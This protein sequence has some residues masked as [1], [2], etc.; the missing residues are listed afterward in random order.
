MEKSGSII[1]TPDQRLRVFISSTLKELADERNSV[2][3]SVESLRLI[4]VMFELGARPHPPKDLYQAYLFQS[5]IFIGIYWQSY[6]WIA[7]HET[8]SGIEDE[9][10]LSGKLPRLIY[11]K[12]PASEREIKLDGLLDSVRSAGDVSYKSFSNSEELY[13]LVTDDLAI[14]ISERFYSA[15]NQNPVVSDTP[16]I[17]TFQTNLPSRLPE[18]IGRGRELEDLRDLIIEEKRNLISITG[19]G[20]IGKTLLSKALAGTLRDHFED[21][22]YFIDLSDI[23][24]ENSVFVEIASV[25]GV[26]ISEPENITKQISDFISTQKILLILDNFEHL[27]S[28]SSEISKLSLI[29]PELTIIITSRDSLKISFEI[30]YR[31][32]AL[33]VPSVSDEFKEIA[34]SPS[35]KL[36][37]TKARSADNNFNLN[38]DNI[39]DVAEIC[40]ILEGI[41]LA[42][43]L[44]AA[45]VRIFSPA[46]ILSRLSKK[47]LILSGGS[48]DAP[49]RHKTMRA[50][51][52]WSIELLNKDE[53]I[54]FRRLAVF[55]DGFDYEALESIC[56][57]CSEG[58]DELS[59]SLILKNIIKKDSEIN[60]IA[61]Y[62]MPGMI[63]EYAKEL[64]ENS[65]EKDDI[66]MKHAYY[67]LNSAKK[68][69]KDFTG[70]NISAAS[71]KWG[72]D[73]ENVIEAAYTFLQ[74]EK[75]SELVNL[76]NSLWQLFWIFDYEAELEKKINL[77]DLVNFQDK[78]TGDD[79]GKLIWLAGVTALGKGDH[80]NAEKYLKQAKDLFEISGNKNGYA[81]AYH[82][83]ASI[84][85]ANMRENSNK[86]IL[87]S[88]EKSAKLFRE[89]GDFWGECSVLQNTAALETLMKHY[90]KA[91]K[92]YDDYEILAKRTK[93]IA[94]QGYINT[95][96]GWIFTNS[97]KYDQALI[98]L[99]NGM[100]FFKDGTTPE[101]LCYTLIIISFYY[102]KIKNESSA[103][104]IAGAQENIRSKYS[105]THWQMLNSVTEFLNT[106]INNNNDLSLREAYHEGM[107]M[108][109][110]KTACTAY[111]ML[112]K[113]K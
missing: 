96:R 43:N 91:L 31:V 21:G 45:K 50:A 51:I 28:S 89:I 36:F 112:Q 18:L 27:T 92:I 95:M 2:R 4:P 54:L 14:L 79:S 26:Q 94:Q 42:I 65:D 44:A 85:A 111:E 81:W 105:I 48:S 97:K 56:T 80:D 69:V 63:L 20:G 88:F 59:E 104:F 32:S 12:E 41:P 90:S 35:V 49:A 113:E 103:F 10:R 57:D 30:E 52:E 75:Y 46:M 39:H 23:K 25:T 100:Q 83:I 1:R 17:K 102:F 87:I 70:E 5:D 60:G 53:K 15:E 7:E 101:A 24:D 76:I 6:G 67:Y 47:L 110:Y 66:K 34:A 72:A 29:C 108:G 61:K 99:R 107:K 55:V 106:K 78:L 86:E 73:S 3:S 84:H 13:K 8:I 64:F 71:K 19:P 82:L 22:V 62:R 16:E 68:D 40:R 33:E 74:N 58:P 98:H 37:L 38:E 9:F 77:S 93:N 11:V 109:I